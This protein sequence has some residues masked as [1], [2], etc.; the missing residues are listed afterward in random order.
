MILL[1]IGEQIIRTQSYIMLFMWFMI[2]ECN[3][4]CETQLSDR[5]RDHD[6][7]SDVVLGEEHADNDRREF[8]R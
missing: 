6:T 1:A 4:T 2:N 5:D 8:R 3:E 7:H